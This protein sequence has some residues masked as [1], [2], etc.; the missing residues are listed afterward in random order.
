MAFLFREQIQSDL[1]KVFGMHEAD[2]AGAE[3]DVADGLE[4]EVGGEVDAGAD[5]G[6]DAAPADDTGAEAPADSADAPEA[7]APKDQSEETPPEPEE[8]EEETVPGTGNQVM[9][10]AADQDDASKIQT[11]FTDTGAPQTDYALTN[12]NNIRLAK[13]RFKRA[14]IEV[15]QMMNEVEQ[16]TGL[17]SDKIIYRLTPEQYDSYKDK[18]KELR[19]Q[20][21]LLEKREKNIVLFN[22]NIP[23]YH[24]D[25]NTGKME[26]IDDS[27]PNLLKNAFKKIDE[28]VTKRFGDNWVDDMNAIDFVQSI[29]VN[30][31]EKESITPNMLTVKY[32]E[33]DDEKLIPFNK[34]YV[35][36]P[37][38]VEEFVR[39]NKDNQNYL[40]SAVYRTLAA[41][42]LDGSTDSNGV[43]PMIKTAEAPAEGANQ[44]GEEPEVT[45]E[46]NPEEAGG[47]DTDVTDQMGLEG[48]EGGDAAVSDTE[49]GGEESAGETV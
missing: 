35:K 39:E 24:L 48:G 29:K 17:T 45:G 8:P 9:S 25:K 12:P 22:S 38:A 20:Y 16:Q 7:D 32:F 41:G 6:A 28:F 10:G 14:G 23:I 2:E 34:L 21:D 19:K 27:D 31:A 26:K 13:F 15:S 4:Q 36:T 40:R 33:N 11:M 3:Q 43:F 30:F 1:R 49:I 47:E 5:P 37:K 42:Y 44:G 18:G 46:E